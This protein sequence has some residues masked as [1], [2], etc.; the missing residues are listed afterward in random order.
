MQATRHPTPPT[1]LGLTLT[2]VLLSSAPSLSQCDNPLDS[3]LCAYT[4]PWSLE[5]E[6]QD[7]NGALA[8]LWADWSNRDS[9]LIAPPA[10]CYPG[11]CAS[12]G[13]ANAA[14]T[15][16]AAI[17]CDGIYILTVVTDDQWMA[18]D[19][20]D[21]RGDVLELFLDRLSSSFIAG[22]GSCR[23]DTRDD[24]LSYTSR[25]L[26]LWMGAG[27]LALGLRLGAHDQQVWFWV[28]DTLSRAELAAL[29]GTQVKVV[30]LDAERRAVQWSIGWGIFSMYWSPLAAGAQAALSIGY[31]DRDSSDS[32]RIA[33]LRGDPITGRDGHPTYHWGDLQAPA[34]WDGWSCWTAAQHCSS[35]PAVPTP[36]TTTR[37]EL[38]SLTGARV[39]QGA[40]F[41]R[42]G[43]LVERRTWS[44]GTTHTRLVRSS[45]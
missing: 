21:E 44:D 27:G 36:G 29:T 11:H 3:T 14:V 9:V 4:V 41:A 38:F 23:I 16:R 37:T 40:S 12:G 43:P 6:L 20:A 22:C 42:Q 25:R 30:Q 10:S 28:E 45:R 5:R 15:V 33:W 32:C 31:S 26:R 35:R 2:A 24:G 39:S 34:D 1:L 8:D 13:S 17:G 19:A 18:A 7:T